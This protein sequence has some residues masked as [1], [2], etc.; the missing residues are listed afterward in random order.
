M[1]KQPNRGTATW[2]AIGLAAYL[3]FPWYAI[4][5]TAWYEVLPQV[6]G[7]NDTANGF[8]QALVFKRVWL[9]FGLFGLAIAA[10]GL[11]LPAGRQQGRWLLV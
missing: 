2:L 8:I 7:G 3:F 9:L 10:A 4:Q 5:D 11:V 1:S 6:L